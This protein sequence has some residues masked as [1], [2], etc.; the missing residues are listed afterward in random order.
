MEFSMIFKGVDQASRVMGKLMA[1]Q[2][3]LATVTNSS[4]KAT[5]AGARAA[6]RAVASLHRRT[7]ALA[8]SGLGDI[9][10][11]L[12]RTARGLTVGAAV[13]TAAYGSATLAAGKLVGTASDFERFQT[14]LETTEGSAAAAREAM[15]WVAD[16]AVK[17]PYELGQIN[18]AFVALRAYGLD[19]TNGMLQTLGDTSAAMNKPLMQAVEAMADAVTGENE[20]L[21]EFGI[22]ARKDGRQII[23]EYTNAAGEMERAVA[24]AGDRMGIQQTLMSIMNS[25]YAGSMERLSQTWDGM[26]SNLW[27]LWAK[28]QL[29]IMNAGLFDW[30]KD[31]LAGVLDFINQLEADGQ[32]AQWAGQ[33][34]DTIQI[35][36][37]QMWTLAV[38][39]ADMIGQLATALGTAAQWVGGWDHL[40]YV[41]GGIA[42]G[43]TLLSTATG[44]FQIAAGVTKLGLALALNP[45]GL[46]IA[47]IAGLAY[48]LVEDWGPV[49]DW[50]R[51]KWEAVRGWAAGGWDS[52]RSAW[53]SASSWF[54]GLWGSLLANAARAWDGIAPAAAS[55]WAAVQGAWS[56]AASWFDGIW[57]RISAVAPAAWAD[58]S[59]AAAA[60]WTDVSARVRAG[61]DDVMAAM[62][63]FTDGAGQRFADMWDRLRASGAQLIDVFGRIGTAVTPAIERLTQSLVGDG[64]G[65]AWETLGQIAGL[66]F[67]VLITTLE[68]AVTVIETVVNG[69]D[70]LAGWFVDGEP[71]DWSVLVPD[72]DGDAILETVTGV[73]DDAITAARNAWNGLAGVFEWPTLPAF[74]SIETAR[75]EEAFAT[76]QRV[77]DR[78]WTFL[79]TTFGRIIT[80]AG[81]LGSAV[82]AAIGKAMDGARAAMDFLAGPQG[83]D[84][85]FADMQSVASQDWQNFTFGQALTDSLKQGETSLADYRAE[86]AAV[87][88]AGGGYAKTAQDLIDASRQLDAFTLPQAAPLP[89]VA[90]TAIADAQ[91][92]GAEIA[93]VQSA[94]QALPGIV[95]TAVGQA[96][97]VLASIS[98]HDHGVRLMETLAAGMR[99]RAQAV[100][101]QISATMQQV[102]DHLPSSPAKA[103][104]LSDLDRLKFGETIAASI[105]S[106]PMVRAMRRAAAATMAAGMVAAP[107]HAATTPHVA[108][109]AGAGSGGSVFHYSPTIHLAGELKAAEASFRKQLEQHSRDLKRLVDGEARREQRRRY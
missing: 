7:V 106:E 3:R 24:S 5:V 97:A 10:K 77:V 2:R 39:T 23:Y 54:S 12:G 81:E 85:V 45:I 64:T 53:Q 90:P 1:G 80:R 22:V 4:F 17:T 60:T 100:V 30:M 61:V 36:L 8:R 70:E 101:D 29:M 43:P 69:L 99:A 96:L 37:G 16:F 57:S 86:L 95:R 58:V 104:P 18:E 78:A 26:I 14:V 76:V 34:G 92:A 9:G 52:V 21:K 94:A 108:P 40:V 88:E 11:G 35:M 63:P 27:D 32:L 73:L 41:L 98:F 65:R 28:F 42:F 75:L 68:G 74:P 19:P 47:A 66:S 62:A 109:S 48:L 84:R 103:G 50:F 89:E 107:A 87:V 15:G 55:A 83:I 51:G 13:V 102:R 82:G 25:K 46:A 67:E 20:R 33:I 38:G 56:G 49:L 105:R 91:A 79:D 93:A 59:A 6:E 31:E 71:I 72:F 44:L